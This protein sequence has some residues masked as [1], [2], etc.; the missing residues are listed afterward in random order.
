MKIKI[1]DNVKVITGKDNAKEGKVV[2]VFP[3]EMKAVVE[4]VNVV[5]KH[6]K[7]RGEE[8]G[9]IVEV[10]RPLAISN[11]MLICPKCKKATRVGFKLVDGKKSRVCKKCEAIFE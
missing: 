10:E 5:K 4:G 8:K 1:N 7:A 2:K 11:L 9:G 3:E 6:I